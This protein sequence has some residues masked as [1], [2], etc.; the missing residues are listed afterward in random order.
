MAS[1]IN[2]NHRGRVSVMWEGEDLKLRAVK[3]E[4]A[5]MRDVLPPVYF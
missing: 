5:W 1:Y 3:K 2:R 4:L